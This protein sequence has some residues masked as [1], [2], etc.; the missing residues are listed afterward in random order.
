MT[1]AQPTPLLFQVHAPQA[2]RAGCCGWSLCASKRARFCHCPTALYVDIAGC[3]H[4]PADGGR[5]MHNATDFSV[6]FLICY[7]ENDKIKTSL[8]ELECT[9]SVQDE[10]IKRWI[11]H[12]A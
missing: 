1:S 2:G 4:S 5:Q 11:K 9:D 6:L 12:C 7:V 10:K 3:G 8:M